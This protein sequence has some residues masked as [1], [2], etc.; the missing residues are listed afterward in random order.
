MG[1]EHLHLALYR[2]LCRGYPRTFRD[3]Y[4]EDLSATFALQ[5]RGRD[6]PSD[7][8]TRSPTS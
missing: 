5:L 1:H 7:T 2:G 6:G 8:F 4:G 3:A